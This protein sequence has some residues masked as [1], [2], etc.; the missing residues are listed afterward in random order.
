M[1]FP[2]PVIQHLYI[3][4][5]PWRSVHISIR[6]WSFLST[7]VISICSSGW[8]H[9]LFG[10]IFFHVD[11]Y[12]QGQLFLSL[13]KYSEI[14]LICKAFLIRFFLCF[15]KSPQSKKNCVTCN[16]FFTWTYGFKMLEKCLLLNFYNLQMV[17]TES[18]FLTWPAVN[19]TKNKIGI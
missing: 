7:A 9:F 13:M 5:V 6:L 16:D 18:A 15:C 8:I 19:I 2:I 14:M 1:G 10:M 4:S 3:E 11:L 12:P 17:L